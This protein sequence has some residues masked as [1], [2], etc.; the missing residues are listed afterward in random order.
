MSDKISAAFGM[1]APAFRGVP[2]L[3]RSIAGGALMGLA[4][5][6]P[7]VSGGTMLLA[8]GLYPQFIAG[9]AE[10]STLKLRTPVLLMLAGVGGS[11]ALAIAAGAQ[12]IGAVLDRYPWVMYSLFIGLAAGGIP[13]VWRLVRPLD[14]TVALS[15]AVAVAA[16]ALL[17]VLDPERVSRLGA[18]GPAAYVVLVVA[19]VSGG[20]AMILPGVSG[21]YLLLVL[22]QYRPI[23]DAVA[24]AVDIARAGAW[25]TAGPVLHVLVPVALGVVAGVAVVSNLVRLLLAARR[26]A[27]LGFLLG[28]LLGA[29]IG[30]WPFTEPVRP[31]VGDVVRGQAILSPAMVEKI[32]PADYRRERTLPSAGQAGGAALLALAGFGASW[33][34]SRLGA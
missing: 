9:V 29:V 22:G 8:V 24:A 33:S 11:A 7:G 27:T 15:A 18:P 4:N 3:L 1:P 25:D 12:A 5:L 23:V 14:R 34:V 17:A 20:A 6:V 10:V 28:L 21:A 30:L 32:D 2:L 19:G 13:I 16:M 31:R 26:R